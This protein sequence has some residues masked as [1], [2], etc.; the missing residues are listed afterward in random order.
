MRL[1]SLLG[2]PRG[3]VVVNLPGGAS[4]APWGP[5]FDK[6]LVEEAI[7]GSQPPNKTPTLLR[8]SRVVRATVACDELD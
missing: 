3:E 5:P 8:A 2:E 7:R 1:R 6:F 4:R